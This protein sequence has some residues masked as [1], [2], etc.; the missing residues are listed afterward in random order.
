MSVQMQ[1]RSSTDGLL[2]TWL[3]VT[4]DYAGA[5]YTGPGSPLD[6]VVSSSPT[7]T[8]GGTAAKPIAAIRAVQ[9]AALTGYVYDN[10]LGTWTAP[11]NGAAP[12]PWPAFDSITTP[13]TTDVGFEINDDTG[14]VGGTP[15]ARKGVATLQSVGSAGSKIVFKRRSDLANN[16]D[17]IGGASF[18]VLDGALNKS[19]RRQLTTQGAVVLGTTPLAFGAVRERDLKEI[20]A[21]KHPYYVQGAESQ[22]LALATVDYSE[23]IKRALRALKLAGGGTLRLPMGWIKVTETLHI[24]SGVRVTGAGR[25]KTFIQQGA[26][27]G[28]WQIHMGTLVPYTIAAAYVDATSVGSANAAPITLWNASS[29]YLD[30]L[31]NLTDIGWYFTK[32]TNGW[33]QYDT[34]IAWRQTE[35]GTGKGGHV[36]STRGRLDFGMPLDTCDQFHINDDGSVIGRVRNWHPSK[37]VR[38]GSGAVALTLS[39]TPIPPGVML[40][41]EIL[42][43]G[44]RGTFRFRVSE[45]RGGSWDWDGGIGAAGVPQGILSAATNTLDGH[46]AGVVLN[47]SNAS[48][49]LDDVWENHELLTVFTAASK[50]VVGTKQQIAMTFDGATAVVNLRVSTIG[51]AYDTPTGTQTTTGT[52]T[53]GFVQQQIYEDSIIGSGCNSQILESR[54]DLNASHG[55]FGAILSQNTIGSFSGNAPAALVSALNAADIWYLFQPNILQRTYELSGDNTSAVQGYLVAGSNIVAEIFNG[56]NMSGNPNFDHDC[57]LD[58]LSLTSGLAAGGGLL[59]DGGVVQTI[60][61]KVQFSGHAKGFRWFGTGYYNCFSDLIIYGNRYAVGLNG[62]ESAFRGQLVVQGGGI[63]YIEIGCGNTNHC[64]IWV[65]PGG[66]PFAGIVC[67]WPQSNV[68]INMSLDGE[69]AAGYR[70]AAC[71]SAP[72]ANRKIRWNGVC[73]PNSSQPFYLSTAYGG[74]S[75]GET[76]IN[77]EISYIT[78]GCSQLVTTHGAPTGTLR[79]GSQFSGPV[80]LPVCDR[81]NVWIPYGGKPVSTALDAA[82]ITSATV[83]TATGTVN[84]YTIAAGQVAAGDALRLAGLAEGTEVR[85]AMRVQAQDLLIKDDA[86]GATVD[87]LTTGMSGTFVY[88]A[89]GT[90][91]QLGT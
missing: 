36:Y 53:G 67:L 68:D 39:G 21:S 30:V 57:A 20:D 83:L 5:G 75:S 9:T 4:P 41:V 18:D 76:N 23:P 13:A 3:A 25:D 7:G 87:T 78:A 80:G 88:R 19:T 31:I 66:T 71:V 42:T 14:M 63:N 34:R 64:N 28:G 15:G 73:G 70:F 50:I 26:R 44:P 45:C 38:T 46:L 85:I 40:R 48:A 58:N 74:Y 77:C 59:V 27:T 11:A 47:W 24:P 79:G 29:S 56:R 54:V 82:A 91:Y 16:A 89:N 90:V 17:F 8:G 12:S 35:L 60:I 65:N 49:A 33:S 62:C 43:A 32:T 2:Y 10:A 37:V 51:S 72:M 1:A 22:S 55:D 69:G 84:C 86:S 6:V 81:L 52:L 61:D